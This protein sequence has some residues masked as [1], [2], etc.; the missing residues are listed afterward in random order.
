MAG[1]VGLYGY[2]QLLTTEV[3]QGSRN[4]Y[5]I[6][7]SLKNNFVLSRDNIR[8]GRYW[9]MLTSSFAH[10][11]FEHLLFNMLSLWGFGQAFI[12]TFGVGQFAVIWI[13]SSVV[14]SALQLGYWEK[15]KMPGVGYE[16][17]G[18]S[19]SIF[20]IL[21][22]LSFVYPRM[23]VLLVFIPMPLRICMLGSAAFSLGA[24]S[25]GWLPWMGHID[26]LGGMAF[27]FMYWL[28]VLRRVAFRGLF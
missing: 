9:V 11:N 18:A 27:G 19:G 21:S 28:V 1:C 5:A 7:K 17:V 23:S 10:A 8:E 24:V 2:E 25:Q 16:A 4:A 14:G 13:G 26:H 15:I 12:R 6:L 3:K 22:A 20:G